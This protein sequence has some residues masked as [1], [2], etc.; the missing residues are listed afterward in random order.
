MVQPRP[1]IV[2][3]LGHV[4]HGKTTLLD[5]LRQTNL[6]AREAGGITQHTR[7]FQIPGHDNQLVT[8]IDTPGHAAFSQ[9]RSRGSRVAD[10]AI[11][12]VAGD[13]GVQPQTMESIDYISKS[14][15]PFIVAITKADL[16][17]ADP[18]RVK[19]QLAQNS[20]LVEE[21]GGSV[22]AVAI[23]SKTGQGI[24][25]LLELINLLSSLN[26]PAA[27]QN[28]SLEVFVL[29]SHLSSQKGPLATVVVQNGTLKVGQELFQSQSIGKVKALTTTSGLKV[30]SALPS[31]PVEILG[32]TTVPP[33][34][35]IIF[36]T[37]Q[38]ASV[39]SSQVSP[40][41]IR[42]DGLNVILKADVAGSLEAIIAGLDP[43]VNLI[44][45]GTGEI[46]EGDVLQARSSGAK[47]IAF[48]TK[49]SPSVA[50]LAEI[51]KVVLITSDII[52]DLFDQ[53]DKLLHPVSTEQILGQGQIVAE[54]K[55]NSDRVAGCKCTEGQIS[56]AIPLR[57]MRSDSVIGTTKIKSLKTGK[58]E[59]SSVKNGVEFGAVF[60]PYLD[61][62]VGD[63]IISVAQHG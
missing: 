56:K 3:I 23:S 12:I 39:P 44:S 36:S 15:T 59:V 33:V 51:E 37:A 8:F 34:G 27:D 32:L 55:I 2:V 11:L 46:S 31:T 24:P 43:A 42:P 10:L 62:K 38:S 16:V 19:T 7:S 26:P 41:A 9:M 47:I 25:E 5:Y 22:P 29:E 30:P 49:I 40:S 20:V 54:F 17:T 28:A 58:T 57:L 63:L 45:S 48:N 18:D 14:K 21:L 4:D 35:S 50:K 13:D 52:Y 6:A 1:P 60:S 61:F 53:L